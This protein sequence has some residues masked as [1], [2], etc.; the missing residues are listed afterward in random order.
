MSVW[1]TIPSARPPVEAEPILQQ[2]RER[3]YKIA[4]W[5]DSSEGYLETITFT[6]DVLTSGDI[7]GTYPGYAQA[8]NRLVA[9]VLAKDP[10]AEW[11]VAAGDD[12]SPDPNHTA[13]E[14][15]AQCNAHF[16]N[17]YECTYPPNRP[18]PAWGKEAYYSYHAYTR[19]KTMG[20]MQPTGDRWGEKPDHPDQHLRT[21]YIDRVCGSAWLGREFC[22][23]VNQGKGPLWPQYT[24]MGVDEELQAVA[25]KLGVLWQ[26]PDLI[27]VHHHW[28]RKR[29]MTDDMPA[30]LKEVNTPKH[31]TAYK[32]LFAERQAAGFPGSECL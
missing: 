22:Q 32:K 28:G 30:F 31:W 17:E 18:A 19:L 7:F 13:E 16:W 2:W 26:R 8:I 14:I 24:H 20:V 12:I 1:L 29:G 21:A 3:G 11:C 4:L 27:H 25:T 6:N 9:C 5:R 23:R 15:A 10:S